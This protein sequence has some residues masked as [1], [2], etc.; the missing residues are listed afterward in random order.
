[1]RAGAGVMRNGAARGRGRGEATAVGERESAGR[2]GDRSGDGARAGPAS[3]GPEGAVPD[4]SGREASEEGGSGDGGS[5]SA[6]RIGAPV[7]ASPTAGNAGDGPDRGA[8]RAGSSADAGGAGVADTGAGVEESRNACARRAPNSS[9][10]VRATAAEDCT[11]AGHAGSSAIASGS[12][13][14]NDG[15]PAARASAARASL[16]ASGV[17]SARPSPKIQREVRHAFGCE[18]GACRAGS[19]RQP[20]CDAGDVG[21][22][23]L[24]DSHR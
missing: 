5:G 19:P 18:D 3:G 10:G 1:M 12:S 7:G 22:V 11:A 16:S 6:G 14:W 2:T 4:G 8:V 21:P 17:P 9:T 20:P 13:S 23:P 24:G 15:G